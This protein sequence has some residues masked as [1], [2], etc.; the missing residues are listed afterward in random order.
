MHRTTRRD[1]IGQ[2][3]FATLTLV[4]SPNLCSAH[5]LPPRAVTRSVP[6]ATG[7][8]MASTP[9]SLFGPYTCQVSDT[10]DMTTWVQ[11][12]LGTSQPIDAIRL[13]PSCRPHKNPSGF[14]VRF[15]IE[16]SNDPDFKIAKRI[17]DWSQN[18]YPDP[19]DQIIEFPVHGVPAR[20]VKLTVTRL[21]PLTGN[22]HT[23][24]FA[25]DARRSY[26]Q[27]LNGKYVFELSKL[28]VLS[29]NNDLALRR[30]VLV[31]LTLGNSERARQ[32]TRPKR[33]QGE[34]IVTDNPQ[35]VIPPERW[36]PVASRVRVP[37]AGVQMRDGLFLRTMKNNLRY[38]LDSFSLDE[39]CTIFACAPVNSRLHSPGPAH[40]GTHCFLAQTQA[41][42]SWALEIV[43]VGS[44]TKSFAT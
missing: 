23:E 16:C 24:L 38:L 27:L 33:P 35:N 34:G 22:T 25:E 26:L 10:P 41:D 36:R 5:P 3:S 1:F 44:N 28:E 29:D 9:S 7:E 43:C 40:S 18:D 8:R 19:A 17:A 31:D 4:V 12:E 15:H 39:C 21:R 30:P 14:P 13:Y 6:G 2:A 37:T 11:I 32:L 42:F 20:Y